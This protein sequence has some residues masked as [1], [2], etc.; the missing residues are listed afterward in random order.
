MD[1]KTNK[2]V[3]EQQ[4]LEAEKRERELAARSGE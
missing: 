1:Y 3:Y 4:S 2:L